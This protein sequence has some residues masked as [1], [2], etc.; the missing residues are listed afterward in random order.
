[1]TVDPVAVDASAARGVRGVQEISGLRLGGERMIRA[2]Y[3]T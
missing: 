2:K 3:V 1:V